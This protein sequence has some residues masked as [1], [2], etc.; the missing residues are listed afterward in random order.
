MEKDGKLKLTY[1][2]LREILNKVVSNKRW[3]KDVKEWILEGGGS[4]RGGVERAM[5]VKKGFDKALKEVGLPLGLTGIYDD[6]MH[7]V[8]LGSNFKYTHT[9]SVGPAKE[10]GNGTLYIIESYDKEEALKATRK[11]LPHLPNGAVPYVFYMEWDPQGTFFRV[12]IVYGD[13]PESQLKKV[14]EYLSELEEKGMGG[15]NILLTKEKLKEKLG[16]K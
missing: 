15:G 14:K 7:F 9:L 2:T 4:Y 16:L 5:F 6:C 11:I 12:E 3:S 8:I 13:N 1:Q 10:D